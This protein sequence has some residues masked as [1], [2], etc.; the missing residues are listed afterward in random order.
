MKR[1]ALLALLAL[2]A[3]TQPPTDPAAR[4]VYDECDALAARTRPPQEVI[5]NN[6][7]G[8]RVR[9]MEARG[10]PGR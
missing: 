4:A 6:H 8:R 1:A 9:C 2:A 5:N 3:C 7:I 10:V